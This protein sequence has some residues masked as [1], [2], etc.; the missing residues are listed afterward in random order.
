MA[1]PCCHKHLHRQLHAKTGVSQARLR[2]GGSSADGSG[3]SDTRNGNGS[4]AADRRP[5]SPLQPLLHHV[6]GDAAVYA[7][8]QLIA[9][10]QNETMART[11]GRVC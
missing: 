2:G 4:Q 11:Q 6:G 8:G 9:R 5:M 3:S 10:E 7:Q 1:V